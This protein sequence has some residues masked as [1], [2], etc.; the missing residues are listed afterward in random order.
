MESQTALGFCGKTK[1]RAGGRIEM[2][3]RDFSPVLP[4]K[5][6]LNLF[7]AKI[8]LLY[9]HYGPEGELRT[10]LNDGRSFVLV[11]GTSYRVPDFGDAA[12]FSATE[13]AA[14][15]IIVDSM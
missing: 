4:Q 5:N 13:N 6:A 3:S 8:V 14:K 12:H 2:R 1:E 7:P 10:E 11:A 15:L 9:V